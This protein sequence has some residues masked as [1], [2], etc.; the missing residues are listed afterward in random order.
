M[1]LTKCVSESMRG[2]GGDELLGVRE[3]GGGT[4]IFFCCIIS[5]VVL[6]MV[7]SFFQSF[8]YRFGGPGR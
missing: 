7:L 1:V 3:E 4:F 6:C 5:L 8:H 2:V